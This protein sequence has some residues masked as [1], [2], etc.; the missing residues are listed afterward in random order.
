MPDPMN[1]Q[2]LSTTSSFAENSVVVFTPPAGMTITLA[3]STR[4]VVVLSENNSP[5]AQVQIFA[6]QA[7]NQNG[8]TGW[9]LANVFDWKQNGTTWMKQGSGRD[10]LIMDVKGYAAGI[11]S[12]TQQ[13]RVAI[14]AKIS[15]VT[16][17]ALVTNEHLAAITGSLFLRNQS[18]TALQ[19]G[20][21][22][23]LTALTDLNL[24]QNS[25]LTALP[26]GVFDD[27][28]AL[29]ELWLANTGQ[30]ALRD[31]VFDNLTA[32]TDRWF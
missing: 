4:Y 18:I 21:F 16:D 7:D 32:L 25:N 31:G 30:T 15:G 2:T 23:G 3:A 28:T 17:C 9:T 5:S 29:R 1:C 6:T 14:L 11:C 13:V 27:L 19:S 20:D 22:A 10:A 24:N 26:A 12:R 8:A